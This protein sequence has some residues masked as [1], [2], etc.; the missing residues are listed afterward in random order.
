M[1]TKKVQNPVQQR[2]QKE[3]EN[4]I[5][6]CVKLKSLNYEEICFSEISPVEGEEDNWFDFYLEQNNNRRKK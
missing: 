4:R 5:N 1:K 2:F 3:E 6:S